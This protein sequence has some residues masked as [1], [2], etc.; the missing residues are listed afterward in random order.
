MLTRMTIVL[1]ESE[2]TALQRMAE[3]DYRYPR[4]VVRR[5]ISEA[6]RARG[7]FQEQTEGRPSDQEV[8]APREA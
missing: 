3:T 6:A 5:L 1:S 2:R 8:S 7:M 4:D